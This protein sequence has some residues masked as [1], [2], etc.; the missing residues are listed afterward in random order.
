MAKNW[1]VK[2]ENDGIVRLEMDKPGTEVNVLDSDSM[3]ELQ[4]ELQAIAGRSDVKALL[5][6]SAKNRIFI[7]GA[8]INEIKSISTEE[9][10]FEKA[11]M[12]GFL[13]Y[14]RPADTDSS[15]D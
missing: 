14:R 4:D 7:A 10:A 5:F 13:A 12:K 6:T 11:E 8:D 15:G 2:E 3:K 9:E 1:Y